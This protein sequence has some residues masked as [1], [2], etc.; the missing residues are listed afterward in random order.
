MVLRFTGLVLL[1]GSFAY[2]QNK[3]SAPG[4]EQPNPAAA[5]P[6]APPFVTCP[7]GAPLGALDLTVEAGG[8]KLPFRTIN[9]LSEGDTLHYAP[10]L[11]GKEKRTGEVA[12]V[13]VPA[14]REPGQEDI[15]VTDPKPAGQP[16]QWRMSQTIALAALVYGPTGLN[17][18]KVARFL[19]QDEVLIAQLADYADKTE[20]AQKLV[21]TLSNRE[22]SADSVNAALNGFAST[23]GF[24]LQID[25]TAAPSTQ[26]ATV[27]T[28][29]NPQLANYNPLAS[30][31][32]QSVGQSASLATMAGTLFFGT[33]VGLAAGGAAMLL[34]LRS[35]AFPDTQFRAS[36]AQPLKDTGLNLCGQQGPV[37]P[38]TRVAYLWANRVPNI[39]APSIQIGA[40]SFIPVGQKTPI[41]VEAS[42]AAWKYLDRMR[43]WTLV[44]GQK[45]NQIPVVTLANQKK[46][47]LDLTKAKLPPGDYSLT[48]LWDWTPMKASGTVHVAALSDFRSA[49][50]EPA[51]QDRLLAGSGKVAVTLAGSDFEFTD[52]VEFGKPNDEFAT[53][54]TVPFRLPKG[55]RQGPQDHMDVQVATDNLDPGP[56]E[57][58]L[59]QQDGNKHP[60]PLKIL[61]NPPKIANL[62]II[63]NQGMAPQHFV[64]KGERLG[65]ITRLEAPGVVFDLGAPLP[66]QT[67]RNV[68]VE[69]KSLPQV[70]TAI[71]INAVLQD[72]SAPQTLAA[73]LQIT[74]P[75]PVI[76]SSKLS[77]PADIGISLRADEFPAGYTFNATLDVKNIDPQG[78]LRLACASGAGDPASLHI[79]EQTSRST[80][81]QLSPD[82][83]FLAFETG[84]LPARCSL[85]AVIDNGQGGSS[86]PFPLAHLLLIPRIDSVTV[87][88]DPPQDGMWNYHL[89]GQALEMIDKLGWEANSGVKVAGLPAPLPGPGLKQAL[90][91]S[92]PAPP[93]PEAT[94]VVWLRGDTQGRTTTLKPPPLPFQPPPDT[95]SPDVPVPA[96]PPALPPPPVL[97]PAL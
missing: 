2:A 79:G 44:E 24:A 38:H 81:Q 96:P 72:R 56:Y 46:L 25:R 35:I 91:V 74:G 15:L 8:L 61:P 71:P 83:L 36:F 33:P 28:A 69:L 53:P 62:P 49:R 67:E 78:V 12:L 17:R 9:N 73:A 88:S 84:G 30:S 20:Q 18:K 63:V 37:P 82:Q 54:E 41:P 5:V 11:Q 58:L 59:Y 92:L 85:E 39:D 6:K 31:T 93:D 42:Q 70:G 32:A 50:V 29:M 10:V 16:Q 48:A 52:K 40:A 23:Y 51:S 95:A 3:G 21:A 13:L 64:L 47:E 34:D 76:V 45:K 87:S 68:T 89:T 66:N 80:L 22:S 97:P 60:V 75:L 26:A 43:E 27:F 1:A 57:L 77:L 65:L 19:S 4:G 94:L 55:L 86:A 7:A 90:D 14:K